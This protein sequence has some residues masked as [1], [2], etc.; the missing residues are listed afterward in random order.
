VLRF[1]FGRSIRTGNEIAPTLMAR[2]VFTLQLSSLSIVISTLIGV[3][4]GVISATRQYSAFDNASMLTA[5]A[6][7]STPIYVTGLLLI[8]VFA[9]VIPRNF[10]WWPEWARLAAGRFVEWDGTINGLLQLWVTQ[11]G[12]VLRHLLLP[13]IAL[14]LY[15]AAI[16]ARMTRAAMLEVIH[17]DYIRTARAYGIHE[18]VITYR[19]ALKNALIPV[20]TVIGLEF[21]M[22]LG[23]AVLTETVFALPGLGRYIVQ[24]GILARDYPIVQAGILLVALVFIVV[25]LITDLTYALID[26][27][28]RYR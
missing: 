10:Q 17:Q 18:R 24:Q 21:G 15:S 26:P 7:I 16:I 23:G 9:V 13:A 2:F 11:P 12:E 3:I 14:G 19:H 25:N 28:I 27:R 22:N 5:L 8:L 20:V 4:A 1:N 6:G